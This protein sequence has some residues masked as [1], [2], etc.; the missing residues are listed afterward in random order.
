MAYKGVMR[1]YIQ[2]MYTMREG[3][4]LLTLNEHIWLPTLEEKKVWTYTCWDLNSILTESKTY[5][6]HYLL[7]VF[8]LN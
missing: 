4:D 1:P 8:N 2:L 3:Q 5:L 7:Y 6:V